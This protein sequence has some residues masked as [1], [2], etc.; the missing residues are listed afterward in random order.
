MTPS[1]P[2]GFISA[3]TVSLEKDSH[4]PG[5]S[6]E[7][8][9]DDKDKNYKFEIV[10][11]FKGNTFSLKPSTLK[12]EE[13]KEVVNEIKDE[14]IN[15]RYRKYVMTVT[16]TSEKQRKIID[17]SIPLKTVGD[18]KSVTM[19]VENNPMLYVFWK[20]VKDLIEEKKGISIGRYEMIS[21]NISLDPLGER[22]EEIYTGIGHLIGFK[23]DDI[24]KFNTGSSSSTSD[25]F[26]TG[27]FWNTRKCARCKLLDNGG[28]YCDECVKFPF[29]SRALRL[30]DKLRPGE[31]I[32]V[33][34]IPSWQYQL[35]MNYWRSS[36]IAS[37]IVGDVKLSTGASTSTRPINMVEKE[38][39]KL[40][41]LDKMNRNRDY[42]GSGEEDVLYV[43]V[44]RWQYR[45]LIETID[46]VMEAVEKKRSSILEYGGSVKDDDVV[47]VN[48]AKYHYDLLMKICITHLE[49]EKMR[50][51]RKRSS[52]S[53]GGIM[54]EADV[55]AT[56]H[57]MIENE[58]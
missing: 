57:R 52:R 4:L 5:E 41:K 29:M 17:S 16:V 15:E 19:N 13:K 26:N 54:S 55:A 33:T 44:Y 25:S 43:D 21:R 2:K 7:I 48:M 10:Y 36:S 42:E 46:D 47:S 18:S 35:L 23:A 56:R 6:K 51:D 39:E 30:D 50:E 58:L 40:K 28:N 22:R 45:M 11:S 3:K 27:S 12:E 37:S 8:K 53:F 24:A 32:V 20:Y 1:G 31:S 34:V 38:L 9:E 49:A 14:K